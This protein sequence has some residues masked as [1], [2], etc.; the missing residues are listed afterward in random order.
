MPT[1][2]EVIEHLSRNYKP[3][4]HIAAAIWCEGDVLGRAKELK[5]KITRKRAQEILDQIDH[6]HDASIGIS[7]DT[8]DCYLEYP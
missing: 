4:E 8:I 6:A 1:V 5:I 3:D 7:W 2:K